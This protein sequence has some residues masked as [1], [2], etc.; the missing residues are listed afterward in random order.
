VSIF[1]PHL[2]QQTFCDTLLLSANTSSWRSHRG[3]VA[4]RATVDALAMVTACVAHAT[5]TERLGLVE[6][7]HLLGRTGHARSWAEFSA[8]HC[9]S[10]FYF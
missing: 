10:V 8:Q 2:A 6:P 1:L 3:A 7:Y 9:Y 4:R 5:R